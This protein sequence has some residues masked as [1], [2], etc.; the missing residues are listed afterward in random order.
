MHTFSNTAHRLFACIVVALS[1]ITISSCSANGAA[2]TSSTTF[3][4]EK[5]HAERYPSLV[6]DW[7]EDLN[8]HDLSNFE[9]EVLERAV[10]TG[11]ITQDDYERAHSLYIQCMAEKGFK[12]A[13]YVKQPDGLYKLVSSSSNADDSDTWWN[14]SIQ[15]SEGTDSLIEAEYRDQQD[16][17]ERYKDPS[18]IAVQ[19]LRDAGKVDDSYTA[20]QFNN[21]ISR[22]N[23]LLQGK[24]L[25][26]IFGFPVD[27][28]DQQT[29]FCLSLGEVDTDGDS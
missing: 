26:K 24:N 27:S 8:R 5:A 17:P 3:E 4:E 15:C 25:S 22:Y 7:K 21:S 18:M 9:R 6:D 20:A 13:K 10:K 11:K 19:C 16:N 14:A 23:R 1:L 28:N 12:G 29:M 2:S